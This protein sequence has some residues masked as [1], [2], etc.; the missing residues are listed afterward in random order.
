MDLISREAVVDA[1]YKRDDRLKK[2]KIYR[3]KG[4]SIDLLGVLPEIRAISSAF[5]GM[6]NGEVI[7]ALFPNANYESRK[8]FMHITH[9]DIGGISFFWEW[10]NAPYKAESEVKDGRN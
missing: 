8:H 2:H 10:W 7:Q 9:E 1:I 4:G 6:T 3:D 5:E